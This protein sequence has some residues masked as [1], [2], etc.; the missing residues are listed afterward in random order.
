MFESC[1]FVV[2]GE[3]CRSEEG[4]GCSARLSVATCSDLHHSKH[5]SL[6]V[7]HPGEEEAM[8]WCSQAL[9]VGQRVPS[10]QNLLQL[11][12]R[13]ATLAY[14]HQRPRHPPHLWCHKGS[15][16][17]SAAA[18]SDH[19]QVEVLH[20]TIYHSAAEDNKEQTCL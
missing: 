10:L 9:W 20:L 18:L 8:G 13:E 17:R 5:T 3:N 4:E 2:C 11:S 14:G 1:G 7:V 6:A 16:Q 15:Y 19:Q 12:H